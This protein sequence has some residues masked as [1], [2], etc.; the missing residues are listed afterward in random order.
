MLRA[1]IVPKSHCLHL[2]AHG[3]FTCIAPTGMLFPV[4]ALQLAQTPP[5][6]LIE[7]HPDWPSLRLCRYAPGHASVMCFVNV[8][9]A[10]NPRCWCPRSLLAGVLGDT[11]ELYNLE[12]LAGF[13]VEFVLLDSALKVPTS[14]DPIVSWSMTAGLRNDTLTALEEICGILEASNIHVQEFHTE[15]PFQLEIATGPL[16][17]MEAID[18]LIYTHETIK[19][20]FSRRNLRATMAP[21]AWLTGPKTGAHLHLSMDPLE[22]ENSF[23]AGMLEH[24]H[25]ISAFS[26]PNYDSFTRVQDFTNGAGTWVCWGTQNR[27]VPVRKIENGHWEL[28]C[29][30]A[31]ANFYLVVFLLL[32]AGLRGLREGRELMLQDFLEFPTNVKKAELAELGIKKHLPTSMREAIEILKAD[33]NID[34]FI[35]EDLKREYVRLKEVDQVALGS[36]SDEERRQCFVQIF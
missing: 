16:R 35:G 6:G 12:F 22:S 31:T 18:A 17:P 5:A 26:L 30:D 1:R 32:S 24:L 29:I 19:H 28:R 23:L 13:E 25:V 27:D 36:M 10:P 7:L 20:V 11:K 21:N 14:V 15:G 2:V 33:R 9:G 3:K 4:S 8:K 34:Q